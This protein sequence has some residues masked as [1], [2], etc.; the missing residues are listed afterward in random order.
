MQCNWVYYI[1]ACCPWIGLGGLF[2]DGYSASGQTATDSISR[3]IPF[4]SVKPLHPAGIGLR[5]MV[6][7]AVMRCGSR[8]LWSW[9]KTIIASSQLRRL[10]WTVAQQDVVVVSQQ[11]ATDQP[12]Q[13]TTLSSS[14]SAD[15]ALHCLYVRYCIRHCLRSA[16]TRDLH[17]Q[18][19]KSSGRRKLA[20]KQPAETK[21]VLSAR[22]RV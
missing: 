15:A 2:W 20:Q 5:R 13:V 10:D 1:V 21:T 17:S 4:R 16:L 3:L 19:A 22:N 9:R 7:V 11:R 14:T 12:Q 18:A 6:L 8:K